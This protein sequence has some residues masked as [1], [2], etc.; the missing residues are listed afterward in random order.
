MHQ[1]EKDIQIAETDQHGKSL[2]ATRD[3]KQ[4]ETVFFAFGPIINKPTI[5]T[6]PI[7]WGLWLD[8]VTPEGNPIRYLC[9]G[10]LQVYASIAGFKT[11]RFF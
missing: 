10:I 4:D 9:H 7:E 6:F 3:F 2:F 5:Y 8:S 11:A 1:I